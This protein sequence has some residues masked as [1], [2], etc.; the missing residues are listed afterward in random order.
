[1]SQPDADLAEVARL[2]A[3]DTGGFTGGQLDLFEE[4]GRYSFDSLLGLG[5]QPEHRVLD[6]GCGALRLGYWLIRYLNPDNYFG[7]EPHENY[8]NAGLRHAIGRKLQEEKKPSFRFDR[9]FDFGAFG[10]RFDFVL[11]RSIFSH[12]SPE[13]FERAMHA[14]QQ[15]AAPCGTMLA[16]YRPMRPRDAGELFD[17]NPDGPEWRLRRFSMPY[18]QAMAARHSLVAAPYGEPFNGQVWVQ[19][20]NA[21]SK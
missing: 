5:L 17:S 13:Q 14:F 11:A 1:M 12:A 21:G 19:L 20:T 15:T 9:D 18:L 16:S 7:T 2:I 4:A 3:E 8:V 6:V 10:V